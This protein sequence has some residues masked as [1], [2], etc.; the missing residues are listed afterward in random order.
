[1]S[2][3]RAGWRLARAFVHVLAGWLTIQLLFPRLGPAQREARVQA[4]A[5]RMLQLLGIGLQLRGQPPARGPLLLVANHISWLD[6][7][8]L[9]AARH[10]RF[11][12]KSQVRQWPLIGPL[13]TGAGTLYI[14]RE[15]RRD[16]LRVVHQM[17][18]SLRAGD[19]LAVFPEGTTSDGMD[20]LPFHSNLLQAAVAAQAPVQPVAL[21]FLETRTGRTSLSPCYIGDDTLVGSLWRTV[22]G[23]A[24]TAVVAFGEPQD[25]DGRDRR[26]WAADLREA[27]QHLRR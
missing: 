7:L 27:V 17:A 21:Q 19:V 11:V 4:W 2:G 16:A 9:H 18:A 13:A 23:P 10:C 3:L 20:L 8:V 6:I 25:A 22:T 12:S 5:R 14:E 24:I 26:A 1:M 15:S